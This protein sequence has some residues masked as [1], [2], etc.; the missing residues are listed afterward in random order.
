MGLIR[1]AECERIDEEMRRLFPEFVAGETRKDE[2][3]EDFVVR[4]EVAEE[5]HSIRVTIDEYRDGDWV[6]NLRM[7]L[8]SL[9]ATAE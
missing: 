8:A 1:T 2:Y 5:V 6:E 9:T 7:A 3:S 4:L